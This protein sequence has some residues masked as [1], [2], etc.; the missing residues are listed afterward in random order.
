MIISCYDAENTA[1]LVFSLSD[2]LLPLLLV[3]RLSIITFIN[4]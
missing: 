1:I 4:E 3:R 2:W